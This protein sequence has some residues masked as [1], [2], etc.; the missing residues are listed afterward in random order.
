M[1][2]TGNVSIQSAAIEATISERKP[3]GSR[4][5]GHPDNYVGKGTAGSRLKTAHR[6]YKKHSR[7]QISL[8]KFASMVARVP[9]MGEK[10]SDDAQTWLEQ[11]GKV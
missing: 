2:I 1:S 3:K 4:A 9:E 10:L 7:E 11:K 5:M 6:V 8:R